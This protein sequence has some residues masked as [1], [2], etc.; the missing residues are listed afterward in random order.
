MELWSDPGCLLRQGNDELLLLDVA[1][2]TTAHKA[3]PQ[4][5]PGP[6]CLPADNRRAPRPQ[7]HAR[8]RGTGTHT[9]VRSFDNNFL[10]TWSWEDSEISKT[11]PLLQELREQW[12]SRK[13]ERKIR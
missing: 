11:Q 12:G 13:E 2:S 5:F 9:L 4:A 7:P 3:W 8:P 6:V 1:S 10:S